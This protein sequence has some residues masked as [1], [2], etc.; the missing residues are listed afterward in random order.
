MFERFHAAFHGLG[1]QLRGGP[2]VTLFE[3]F[4]QQFGDRC[5]A[6]GEAAHLAVIHEARDGKRLAD[7]FL[8]RA[9]GSVARALCGEQELAGEII[10]L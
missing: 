1:G 10:V 3:A 4:L 9:R 2:R 7:R 8:E 5:R 6:R